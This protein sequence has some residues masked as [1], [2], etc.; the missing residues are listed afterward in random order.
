MTT[1]TA[2]LAASRPSATLMHDHERLEQLLRALLVRA[3]AGDARDL[4]GP[5]AAFEEGVRAHLSAEEED[6]FPSYATVAPDEVLAL[7]REHAE[8][9]S[10]L[11]SAGLG[12]E[13]HTARL[14]M[15]EDLASRLR[16]HAEHEDRTL[17][18]FLDH[19]PPGLWKSAR[20]R[21]SNALRAAGG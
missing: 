7:R 1:T 17:Y 15:L 14:L 12:V 5:W 2:Q 11:D 13:L 16:E 21:L 8:I 3:R 19:A 18:A 9:R 20:E 10:L 6:L 4:A